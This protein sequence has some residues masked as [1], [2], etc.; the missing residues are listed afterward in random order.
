MRRFLRRFILAPKHILHVKLM[1][2]KIFTFL[3]SNFIFIYNSNRVCSVIITNCRHTH[4]TARKRFTTITRHQVDRPVSQVY[5]EWLMALSE[6]EDAFNKVGVADQ[7]S[8]VRF[9][10]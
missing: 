2:K 3:R 6:D 9:N 5:A 4:G 10:F 8:I 1:G 7:Q